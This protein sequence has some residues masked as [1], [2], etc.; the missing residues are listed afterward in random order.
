[1]S[2]ND[3]E[4]RPDTLINK[5]DGLKYWNDLSPDVDSMLGGLSC[6]DKADLQNSRTFLA[7]LGI[8]KQ[9]GR[10]TVINTLEGG[11]G[12]VFSDC[13][14]EATYSMKEIYSSFGYFTALEE[15]RRAYSLAYLKMSM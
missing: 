14:Y 2:F 15:S 10:R 6:V 13:I 1:M 3:L 4:I 11:A 7:K 9:S 12:Y 8:G 5:G